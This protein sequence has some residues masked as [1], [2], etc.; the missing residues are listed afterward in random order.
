[1]KRICIALILLIS[2]VTVLA[3]S[4]CADT[5]QYTPIDAAVRYM[6]N[7]D[8]ETMILASGREAV[9]ENTVYHSESVTPSNDCSANVN[10]MSGKRCHTP[11]RAL[12]GMRSLLQQC[13]QC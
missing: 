5:Y 10:T 13:L 3:L 4:A 2:I 11:T 9:A 7:I 12:S 1:M 6:T 8:G